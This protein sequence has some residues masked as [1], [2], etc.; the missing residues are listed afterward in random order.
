MVKL[1]QQE[2]KL[3]SWGS[4]R[5]FMPSG[6][7]LTPKGILGFSVVWVGQGESTQH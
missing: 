2:G 7:L 5:L 6:A 3:G 1:G 4:G